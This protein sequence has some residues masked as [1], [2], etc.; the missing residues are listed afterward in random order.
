[1][2]LFCVCV[3]VRARMLTQSNDNVFVGGYGF[4]VT[5]WTAIFNWIKIVVNSPLLNPGW[6]ELRWQT[7][8][9]I[10]KLNWK[11]MCCNGI[12]VW[13]RSWTLLGTH[14]MYSRTLIIWCLVIQHSSLSDLKLKN[15]TLNF[16]I[17]SLIHDSFVYEILVLHFF[18]QIFL[19]EYYVHYIGP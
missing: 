13:Q 1:M 19:S 8:G 16:K 4:C 18:F 12:L 15:K 9:K 17:L 11:L 2:E 10:L 6:V 14:W 3:C 5:L 7:R